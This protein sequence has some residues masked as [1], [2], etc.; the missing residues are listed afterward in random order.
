MKRI[1]YLVSTL[2]SSGPTNQLSYIIKYLNRDVYEPIILTLSEESVSD[3][4][5]P[6]FKN[7]LDVRVETLGLNRIQG[8]FLAKSKIKN[9]IQNN[10]ID[11]VHSQGMRADVLMSKI[12]IVPRIATLRNYPYYDYPMKFGKL[13][14]FMMALIHLRAIKKYPKNNMSCSKT[15]SEEFKKHNLNLDYIQNGVD[16]EIFYPI[17]FAKKKELRRKLDIDVDK[18]IFIS[19][20]NLIARK[21]MFTIIQA[22]KNLNDGN[23]ILI[24]AGDGVEYKNLK[25]VSN[26]NIILLGKISNMVEYFQVSDYFVSASFAEG[27]PNTVL[28]AMACGMPTILSNIP[29]HLEL[30]SG[31]NVDFFNPKE[32]DALS[33]L[34]KEAIFGSE[35][36][37]DIPLSLVREKFDAKI[38][39]EKYQIIYDEKI[40]KN[41]KCPICGEVEKSIILAKDGYDIVKCCY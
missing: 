26:K 17:D 13:I 38:M 32:V 2:K 5:M 34:L 1:L 33:E 28:E 41:R 14:G 9:F 20:G 11:L 35:P 18:K 4:M 40:S 16:T 12:R 27:L 30:Y 29:S 10:N 24:I 39:S 22:F 6:F 21:N 25:K 36:Q 8:I 7:I 31:T 15:I 19:A 3:S 37:N 23:S